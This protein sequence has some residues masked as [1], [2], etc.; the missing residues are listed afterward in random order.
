[1]KRRTFFAVIGAGLAVSLE[2]PERLLWVPGRKFVSIPTRRPIGTA[3]LFNGSTRLKLGDLFEIGGQRYRVT[4]TSTTSL[5]FFAASLSPKLVG[6]PRFHWS[7]SEFEWAVTLS[8]GVPL[9]SVPHIVGHAT[10]PL[11]DGCCPLFGRPIK[12]SPEMKALSDGWPKFWEDLFEKPG[13]QA[14]AK[15]EEA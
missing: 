6:A 14:D 9:R 2:D 11:P 4:E 13:P 15:V 10:S 1:M 3:R 5:G 8:N 7:Y 12:M